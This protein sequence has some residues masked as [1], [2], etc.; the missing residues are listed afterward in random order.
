MTSRKPLVKVPIMTSQYS[1]HHII[2]SFI[3]YRWL[4]CYT[5]MQL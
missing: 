2:C 1:L 4:E 5:S 3:I